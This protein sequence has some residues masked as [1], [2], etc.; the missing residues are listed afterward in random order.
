MTPLAILALLGAAATTEVPEQ[1]PD[2]FVFWQGGTPSGDV[3]R[4]IALRNEAAIAMA[5]ARI[6]VP[7]HPWMDGVRAG[8]FR[9]VYIEAVRGGAAPILAVLFAQRTFQWDLEVAFGPGFTPLSSA[10]KQALGSAR[11]SMVLLEKRG[12]TFGRVDVQPLSEAERAQEAI[13]EVMF[14]QQLPGVRG[15]GLTETNGTIALEV[16]VDASLA[17]PWPGGRP[18]AVVQQVI[19]MARP[20]TVQFVVSG[21]IVAQAR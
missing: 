17:P 10:Q 12:E 19:A 21:P 9:M 6:G 16:L 4:A 13:A 20:V 5:Q 14:A 3:W 2:A 1:A 15:V 11:G 7:L 8:V 18:P